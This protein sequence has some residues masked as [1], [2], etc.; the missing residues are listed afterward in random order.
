MM[1]QAVC[2]CVCTSMFVMDMREQADS[3]RQVLILQVSWVLNLFVVL[4]QL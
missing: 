4:P 3:Y 2:I 1:N